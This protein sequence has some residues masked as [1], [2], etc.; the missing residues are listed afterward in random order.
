[1]SAELLR[2]VN[3]LVSDFAAEYGAVDL[4]GRRV[5]CGPD[6]RD[7]LLDAFETFGVVGGAGI[8]VRDGAGRTLLV[9]YDGADGWVDPGDGRR[10]GE[11]YRE[12]AE[13]GVRETTGIEATVDGL[14]QV[15]LLYMDD[16]TDRDPIPNPYV[17]FEGRL[18]NGCRPGE[19]RPGDGVADLRWA[20]EVPAEL[21]YDELA[22]LSLGGSRT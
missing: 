13:R 6:D 9:R 16:W 4:V 20:E 14:A 21:L 10:P 7:A 12:C 5:D 2:H 18:R 8:R 17:S 15:H 22:E 11:S 19:A 3:G 1:M